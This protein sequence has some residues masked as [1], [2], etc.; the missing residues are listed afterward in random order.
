MNDVGTKLGSCPFIREEQ[1]PTAE[2]MVGFLETAV[3]VAI[4]EEVAVELAIADKLAVILRAALATGRIATM[5]SDSRGGC[6][7]KGKNCLAV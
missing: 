6:G 3:E 4:G 7:G 2:A 1:L 5:M